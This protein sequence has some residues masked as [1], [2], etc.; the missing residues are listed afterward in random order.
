MRIKHQPKRNDWAEIHLPDDDTCNIVM[1]PKCNHL[2]C[3]IWWIDNK[4]KGHKTI[5]ITHAHWL[6]E[7]YIDRRNYNHKFDE[8]STKYKPSEV[9]TSVRLIDNNKIP[10]NIMEKFR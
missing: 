7:S 9:R 3:L 8:F 5:V 4:R 6:L 2:G 10:D 1:C